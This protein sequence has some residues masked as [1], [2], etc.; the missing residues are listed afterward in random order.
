M[1]SLR[2]RTST[3]QADIRRSGQSSGGHSDDGDREGPRRSRA[4]DVEYIQRRQT[5]IKQ[6]K[7]QFEKIA[8]ED[9]HISLP[10]FRQTLKSRND[11][12]TD[13]LFA[14]FDRRKDGR[15]SQDE[16]IAFIIDINTADDKI[17]LLFNLYDLSGDGKL[18][19][20]E[21]ETVIKAMVAE[22]RLKLSAREV[23]NLSDTFHEQALQSTRDEEDEAQ[24][25]GSGDK[26]SRR[27]FR[28]LLRESEAMSE[29]V[30]TLI[31]HWI[32]AVADAKES[33]EEKKDEYK[34]IDF[35]TEAQANPTFYSFFF[36]YVFL[37]VL[38]MITAAFL[39]RNAKDREGKR[40]VFLITARIFGFPL[41]FVCMMMYVFMLRKLLDALRGLGA[42]RFL[43]MDHNLFF[44]MLSGWIIFIFGAIHTVVHF[45]N[46]RL[47]VVDNPR[48]YLEK[49]NLTPDLAGYHPP[50]HGGNYTYF[51]WMFTPKPHIFGLIPGWANPTGVV[52]LILM[53]M[54]L[55]TS[56]EF[57]RRGGFFNL[58]YFCH[59]GYIPFA[60]L[61][62][63]HAPN[64]SYFFPVIG[65]FVALNLL[66]HIF[67]GRKKT[68]LATGILLPSNAVCL[69]L[70]K[71]E[72]LAYKTG[73]WLSINIPKIAYF[74]WHA[75]TISSSPEM[76]NVLTL[77]IKVVGSWTTA[78]QKML[79][80]HYHKLSISGVS[81]GKRNE[82]K[83]LPHQYSQL[84]KIIPYG[85]PGKHLQDVVTHKANFNQEGVT[86]KPVTC[87]IEG[88]FSAPATSIFT[89][90]HAVLI[91]TGVGVTPMTSILQAVLFRHLEVT[92]ECPNC[93]NR[94]TD[95]S[96]RGFQKLKKLDFIWIVKD[97]TEVSWF[98][99]LL[100][101]IDLEQETTGS[102]LP[103]MIETQ[104]Y[105]TRALAKTDMCAVALR[106][107]LNLFY[108]K[109]KRDIVYGLRSRM[110]AGRPNL[111]EIFRRIHDNRK[112]RVSVYYC[113]NPVVGNMLQEKCTRYGF[114]MHR[115]VF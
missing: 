45:V 44:H 21:I 33:V 99:D 108:K 20:S 51:D 84:A 76:P 91:A 62:I 114:N 67:F 74:E 16:F 75:F 103:K 3:N 66:D 6:L 64:F 58:F 102:H 77:H 101:G 104:I 98:L 60:V 7:K 79:Q 57:V 63:L 112:G 54:M 78:L 113:G 100:A 2:R 17:D 96:F 80:E 25:Y 61:L 26:V 40:N 30:S 9:G 86:L 83:A 59:L 81:A 4:K 97:P 92:H 111:N 22:S 35:A 56:Q 11:F 82:M 115:E 106:I 27:G 18:D 48:N 41:N 14:M 93:S 85:P 95:N 69:V 47:N 36:G 31:D 23:K 89:A 39:H 13:K 71:S 105:V 32:G 29:D 88:P 68:Y 90:E 8:G 52:L 72:R 42:I 110:I 19:R 15:I 37:I 5:R 55:V 1:D 50:E 73:D 107:A 43:P 53:T 70:K 28:R 49:N 87:Y 65:V 24:G 94:W 12:F 109:K 38:M 10:E 46:F 34:A